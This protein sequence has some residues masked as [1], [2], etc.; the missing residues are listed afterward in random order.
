MSPKDLRRTKRILL[1]GSISGFKAGSLIG[2]LGKGAKLK[3]VVREIH[4]K[5][6]KFTPGKGANSL[7]NDENGWFSYQPRLAL[8][9]LL[10]ECRVSL[11]ML[12]G[13]NE[14]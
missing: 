6:V 11:G 4:A 14:R 1:P 13:M 3:H 8:G 12:N 7:E 2:E 5:C 9:M 10:S